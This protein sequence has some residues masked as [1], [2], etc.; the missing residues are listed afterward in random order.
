MVRTVDTFEFDQASLKSEQRDNTSGV[1]VIDC[2]HNP[3]SF[4]EGGTVDGDADDES[5]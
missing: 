4:E 5:S 2:L 3:A 1:P